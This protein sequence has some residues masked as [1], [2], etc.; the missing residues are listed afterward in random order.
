VGLSARKQN[1]VEAILHHYVRHHTK[2][3]QVEFEDTKGVIRIGKS[4]KNTD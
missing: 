3:L 2:T 4:K 1:V